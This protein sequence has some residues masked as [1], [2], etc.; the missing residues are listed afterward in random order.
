M[1]ANNELVTLW[2]N[3]ADAIRTQNGSTNTI[4]P[5]EYPELIKGINTIGNGEYPIYVHAP[6]GTTVTATHMGG[7]VLR[8]S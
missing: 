5:S 3:I 6:A 4:T 1:D 2:G 7:G 8:A